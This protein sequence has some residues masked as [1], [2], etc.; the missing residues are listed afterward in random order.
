M[1]ASKPYERVLAS[2][3]MPG[4]R[5]F[6]GAELN[7]A[8]NLLAGHDAGGDRRSCTARSCA[9]WRAE[10]GRAARAGRGRGGGP[11]RARR[12]ARRPR[13]RLH[14]EHPRDADRVPRDGVA[15]RDLVER[16]PGVRRPQRDR[17]F[18]ADRAEGVPDASTATATAAR[19]STAAASPPRSSPSYRPSST[20]CCWPTSMRRRR[21]RG[22]RRR[23][24]SPGS[25][26]C[27]GRRARRRC[28]SSRSPSITRCGCST[29]PARPACR[30]RSCRATAASCSS[31]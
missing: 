28:A 25:S 26:C 20:P 23:V 6:E 21:A 27:A 10:L 1:R 24:R 18:C 16:R 5:W 15:R 2:H 19:T 8:E 22:A 4:T 13:G 12:R 17:P 31:S 14:A 29:P 30:R 11:A 7:Y 9:S 3:E